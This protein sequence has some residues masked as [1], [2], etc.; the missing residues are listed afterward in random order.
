MLP[1]IGGGQP[2]LKI[3]MGSI[4]DDIN[5]YL[6]KGK[7]IVGDVQKTVKD[8]TDAG[9]SAGNNTGINGGT[10]ATTTTDTNAVE[11]AANTQGSPNTS[12]ILL[13]SAVG[14]A[15]GMFLG[16]WKYAIAGA[17][18]TGAGAYYITK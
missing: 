15:L 11:P 10:S 12:A 1:Q 16:G 9:S 7:N 17:A 8:V 3:G 5:D 13:G 6:N 18:M 14:G 2:A 4:F